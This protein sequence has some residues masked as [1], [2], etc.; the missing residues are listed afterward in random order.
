VSSRTDR[1]IQRNP[2]SKKKILK[3]KQKNTSSDRVWNTREHS[4]IAGGSKNWYN[5]SEKSMWQF[6]NKLEIV[7]PQD[8]AIS[9]LGIYPKDTPPSHKDTGSTVF[10]VALFKISRNWKHARYPSTKEWVF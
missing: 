1:T 10:I 2:V 4:S 6:L 9:L 5:H 8:P 3:Q 7:L